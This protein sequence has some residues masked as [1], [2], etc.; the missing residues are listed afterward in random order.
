MRSLLPVKNK[1]KLPCIFLDTITSDG[2]TGTRQ[3]G[4][5]ENPETKIKNIDIDE[6]T[7]FLN[8]GLRQCHGCGFG[9]T[10][11]QR[12]ILEDAPF[13]TD[14]RMDN[15]HSDVYWFMDMSIKRIPVFVD[16]DHL[17]YHEPIP[18]DTVKDR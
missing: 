16:T 2:Q 5:I 7:S 6:V 14:P 8:T 12:E 18:W 3:L 10:L 9:C 1:I 13:W 15:K 17:I 11:I 4:I